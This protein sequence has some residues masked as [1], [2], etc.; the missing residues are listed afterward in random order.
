MWFWLADPASAR[1]SSVASIVPVFQWR[2]GFVAAN[3][4]AE[5][6]T[7][8]NSAVFVKDSP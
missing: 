8:I 7:Q 1:R 2:G 4:V 6:N 5:T 3:S